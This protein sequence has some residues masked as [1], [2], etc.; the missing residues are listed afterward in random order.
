[1]S[2]LSFLYKKYQYLTPV[3]IWLEVWYFWWAIAFYTSFF[4]FFFYFLYVQKDNNTSFTQHHRAPPPPN[5]RPTPLL[6]TLT[7]VLVWRKSHA[8][9]LGHERSVSK[10]WQHFENV[11][12]EIMIFFN[13]LENYFW[14]YVSII[15]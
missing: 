15:I 5:N 11:F 9:N 12:S 13:L 7:L 2:P 3:S 6:M 10:T 1:M 4:V 14:N 8:W